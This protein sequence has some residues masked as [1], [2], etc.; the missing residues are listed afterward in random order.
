[1]PIKNLT[2]LVEAFAL[3]RR[4]IAAAHLV[5]VGEGP[6]ATALR[7]YATALDVADAVTF[8]GAVPHSDMPSFY[9]SADVFALSSAFDNSPNVILEAMA[10]GLPVVTTDV[11]GVRE[12]VIDGVGGALVERDN[13]AQFASALERYLASPHAAAVAGTRGR[14]RTLTEFS[15]HASALK[16]LEVYH[17]VVETRRGGTARALA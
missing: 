13:A 4:R 5:I 15:W 9:R 12:F 6:E 14:Q 7:A 17:R 3:V 10:C 2:L 1:V 8:P 16:L 11:G